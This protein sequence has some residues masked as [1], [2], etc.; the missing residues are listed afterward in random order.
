MQQLKITYSSSFVPSGLG[1]VRTTEHFGLN[2][3]VKIIL[4]PLNQF[5]ASTNM[6][7]TTKV[8]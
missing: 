3:S 4:K 1:V 8:S 6:T 2:V 7:Y 5:Q